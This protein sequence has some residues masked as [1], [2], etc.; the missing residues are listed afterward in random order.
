MAPVSEFRR[1]IRR[2]SQAGLMSVVFVVVGV[3]GWAGITDISGAVIASGTVVV[4]SNVKKVQHPTG[5]VVGEILKEEG[6]RVKAGEVLVRLDATITRANLAM[7]SKS[8]DELLARRARL[9]AERD[10]LDEVQFP[11]EL[12][13]RKSEPGVAHLMAGERRLFDIRRT[14]R[15]GQK[16]QLRQRILQLQEE[17]AGNTAQAEAKA[18]EMAIIDREL[19]GV[20]ELWEQ[21]LVA[22]N[23]LSALERDES[24]AEGE[25][26]K[27]RS[28]VAETKGK[29]IETELQILQIDNDF[30]SEVGR[31]LREVESGIGALVERN[32]AAKDQLSR[33]D[34]RAPQD[35][36]VHEATV[37]TVGGVVAG[38]EPLMLIVPDNGNLDVEV[39][40]APQDIDQ[41][42][43]GQAANLR[44]SA[45]NQRTTPEVAGTVSRISADVTVDERT[46]ASFYT[47]R[48]ALDPSEKAR[49]GEVTLVPGMP[50]EAFIKTGDRNV[51]SYLSKPLTD[52]LAHAFRE[53]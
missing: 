22:I 14:V 52:Q 37:H 35:G 28:L 39:K 3:G 11:A 9:E 44:F 24:R 12:T 29:V 6:D 1:S 34:I 17:I 21:E 19:S 46:S 20:R 50:V 13:D 23:R 41:L 42:S 5:G 18:K 45:F 15:L 47:V 32:I 51:I 25:W 33:I 7:V 30:T 49:L 38:G 43:I 40:V 36:T 53:N 4:D 26:A 10:G 31:E 2:H 8:L 16:T 27:L 48:V